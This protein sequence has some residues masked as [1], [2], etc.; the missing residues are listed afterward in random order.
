MEILVRIAIFKYFKS[1]V[2]PTVFDAV[3]LL[4]NESVLPFIKRFDCHDW[5]VKRLWNEECDIVFKYYLMPLKAI[6]EKCSG[7]FTKPGNPK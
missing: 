5:R 4:M 6:Y 7:K 1:K 3:K 2:L